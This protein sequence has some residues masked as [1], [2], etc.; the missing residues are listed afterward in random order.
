MEVES[1]PFEDPLAA[2]LRAMGP[3]AGGKVLGNKA[4]LAYLVSGQAD[5][6]LRALSDWLEEGLRVRVAD[7]AFKLSGTSFPRGSLILRVHENPPSLRKSLQQAAATHG[8]TI[9]GTDSAFVEEGAHLGGPHVEWVKPPRVVLLMDRP[10]SP[11]SGHTWYLFD[12]QLRY[13]TTRVAMRY[14]DRLDLSKY[15]V[16]ILPDG[17][18]STETAPGEGAVERLRDWV[19]RGGTL[20]AVKG[21]A[22]WASSD[23]VKL[24]ASKLVRQNVSR[25]E[26]ETDSGA[27]DKS[28]EPETEPPA[29]VPGAFL[30]TT[31]YGDHWVTFGIKSP[32]SAFF[33]GNLIFSPL[34]PTKGR[35]L[36]T[37]ARTDDDLLVSGF[38]WPRT[39]ELLGEKPY[40]LY[41]SLG[42][43]HIVAFADDPNFRAMYPELQRLFFNAVMFGPG[44]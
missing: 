24:L 15:N 1:E 34:S 35:N 43:G 18:Y 38:C 29:S 33:E 44:H 6:V 42:S 4:K 39:L 37:F 27:G 14:L 20:I 11:F 12:R 13:P 21:G 41:Q 32:L 7:Q 31:V 2:E 25:A 23:K 3:R 10:L 5:G 8:L 22:V 19:R 36:V 17:R 40:V 16:L 26:A 9:H 30:K 28:P